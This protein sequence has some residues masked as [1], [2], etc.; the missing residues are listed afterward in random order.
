MNFAR[1]DHV[2]GWGHFM[3]GRARV[4]GRGS[5][6]VHAV[7]GR[8]FADVPR[9]REAAQVTLLEEE[10]IMIEMLTAIKRAGADLI[11]TYFAKDAAKALAR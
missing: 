2:R 10:R 11:L 4:Q 9:T 8:Q 3:F 7:L 5:V 6:H 1:V